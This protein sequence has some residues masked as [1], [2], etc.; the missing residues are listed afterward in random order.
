MVMRLVVQKEGAQG[1]R[2]A[3]LF[4]HMEGVA[5]G[6]TDPWSVRRALKVCVSRHAWNQET[7]E[8]MWFHTLECRW[9]ELNVHMFNRA[10]RPALRPAWRQESGEGLVG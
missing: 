5:V 8:F 2:L 1:R 6:A 3:E 7:A 10:L 9:E 4:V